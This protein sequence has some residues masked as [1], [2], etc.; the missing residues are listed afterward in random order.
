MSNGYRGG[1]EKRRKEKR[2]FVIASS[3]SFNLSSL[4][5][6]ISCITE[7]C[8]DFVF[9]PTPQDLDHHATLNFAVILDI[10]KFLFLFLF[11]FFS[12]PPPKDT[13]VR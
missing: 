12:F 4:C 7:F 8:H 10:G 11:F 3:C 6:L 1:E 2:D 9:S 13:V 5:V